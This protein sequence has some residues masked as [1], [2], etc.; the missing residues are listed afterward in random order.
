MMETKQVYGEY[1]RKVSVM[2][3]HKFWAG[4]MLVCMIM[5]FITGHKHL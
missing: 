2:K 5:V 3:Q 1:R 4:A